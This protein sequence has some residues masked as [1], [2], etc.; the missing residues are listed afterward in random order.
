LEAPVDNI[1]KKVRKELPPDVE[2]PPFG[3]WAVV[4]PTPGKS[5]VIRDW[6]IG[7]LDS[8]DS[9][10]NLVQAIRNGGRTFRLLSGGG[11]WGNKAGLLSLDPDTEP[12]LTSEEEDILPME[13]DYYASVGSEVQFFCSDLWPRETQLQKSG[14]DGNPHRLVFGVSGDAS[15]IGSDE[16]AAE[17]IIITPNHFGAISNSAIY[18]YASGVWPWKLSVPG[19]QLGIP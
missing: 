7:N 2:V 17:D 19:S 13:F 16:V 3:V 14:S 5:A 6:K 18:M 12:F 15:K 4:N 11:G 10:V 8:A 9:R 1:Y